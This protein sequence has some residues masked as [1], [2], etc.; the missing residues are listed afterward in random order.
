MKRFIFPMSLIM[1]L[2]SV[3]FISSC[4]TD[5]YES[6]VLKTDNKYVRNPIGGEWDES[7]HP[8]TS[9]RSVNESYEFVPVSVKKYLYRSDIKGRRA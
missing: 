7:Y 3:L 9:T 2:L 5:E 4:T 8:N 6:E 1:G